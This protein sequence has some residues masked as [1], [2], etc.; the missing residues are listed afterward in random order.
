MIFAPRTG[1][2]GADLGSH[3]VKL[4]QVERRGGLYCLK[5]ALAVQRPAPWPGNDLHRAEARSSREELTAAYS[6]GGFAGR[7]AACCLSMAACEAA[8]LPDDAQIVAED[9]LSVART[10]DELHGELPGGRVADTWPV[11]PSG[12]KRQDDSRMTLSLSRAWA[13]QVA[14]DH[15]QSGLVCRVLDG[16]PLCLAR[17]IQMTQNEA[18]ASRPVAA[19]DWGCGQ[20]T[21]C[22]VLHGAPQFVR[23]LRHCQLQILTEAL[24]QATGASMAETSLL[25]TRHGLPAPTQPIESMQLALADPVQPSL[26]ALTDEVERTMAYLRSYR[27]DWAPK[28]FVL[29]GGGA[30]IRNIESVLQERWGAPVRAW[31]MPQDESSEPPNAPLALFGPAAALSLLGC[32]TK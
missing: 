13:S 21:L 32:A 15:S 20:A 16:L 18:M 25:L 30:T 22:I 17:A 5:S 26:D 4:A 29:F 27:P 8:E 28:E 11:A 10:L 2:I 3:A 14:A 7:Y 19:L 24:Q 12:G 6:L 31:S 9:L 1:W 23:V